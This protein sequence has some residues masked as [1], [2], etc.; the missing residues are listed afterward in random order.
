MKKALVLICILFS[1]RTSLSAS[2]IT[3]GK[4]AFSAS[5]MSSSPF[6]SLSFKNSSYDD[7]VE[8]AEDLFGTFV[9]LVIIG[10]GIAYYWLNTVQFFDYPYDENSSPA[11]GN[12]VTRGYLDGI[13]YKDPGFNRSR[14]SLDSSL[15]YLHGFGL[16]NETRFEGLLFPYIGPYFENLAL[17]NFQS[18]KYDFSE[19]GVRDNLKIGGQLSLIQSNLL[20]T[21][22]LVQYTSWYSPQFDFLHKGCAVGILLRSYP[23]KPLV[24]EWKLS[25]QNY[26][27][28]FTVFESDFHLGVMRKDYEVFASWKLLSFSNSEDES[29]GDDFSGLTLGLRKY[30]SLHSF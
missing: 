24:I 19:R 7:D 15:V 9:I 4:K 10:I 29:F 21:N 22:L 13:F 30:F 20:I 1:L 8:T 14:F 16:G 11:D 28:S 17:Y 6:S 25:S 18:G 26:P 27:H 5:L 3:F 23:V 2:D 12:Y